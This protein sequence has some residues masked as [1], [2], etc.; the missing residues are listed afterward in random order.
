M[1]FNFS[2]V[3]LPSNISYLKPYTIYDNVVIDKIE[4]KE[5]T[6][7][8]G[9]AWKNM[10]IT[11]KCEEGIHNESIF[12]ITDNSDFERNTYTKSDGS[13]GVLPSNWETTRDTMA[14]IGLT[15]APDVFPKLQAASTKAKSFDEIATAYIKM[16]NSV[17]GKV[18]TSM[19]LVGKN[20]NGKVYAAL[21]K[22]IGI[23]QATDEKS[24]ESHGVKL[25]E[26]YT[27]LICPFGNNLSFTNYEQQQKNKLNKAKPTS[28]D[29]LDNSIDSA[30]D[31]EIDDFDKLLEL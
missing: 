28:M 27:W 9:K 16:I 19:K 14:A 2:E 11:F 22:C 26:Y 5:G 10:T 12:W 18:S 21:P 13:T 20:S 4:V 24:A 30:S 1:N 31:T 29:S 23:A 15:F 17:K 6:S 3:T 8:K 25:N 7:S